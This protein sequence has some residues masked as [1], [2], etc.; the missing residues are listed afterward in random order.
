MFLG[1]DLADVATQPGTMAL[2]PQVVDAVDVPVIAAGG[3]ADGRGIAAALALGASGVQIGTAYLFCPEATISALHAAALRGPAARR[4]AL[5]NVFSGRPARSI[6]TRAMGELGPL[7]A[8]AAP[9]PVAAEAVL[10]LRH[11]A[12][13]AG[14]TTFTSLWSGQSAALGRDLTAGELTRVLA[15]EAAATLRAL[16]PS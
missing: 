6:V 2:V 4:T 14:D 1:T 9:F 8:D 13:A 7:S 15:D 5:T 10:P 16:R 11:A 12:E 3:I